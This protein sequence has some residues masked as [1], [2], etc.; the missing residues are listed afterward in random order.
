MATYYVGWDVGAWHKTVNPLKNLSMP[1]L[2]ML[3]PKAGYGSMI[4]QNKIRS[5]IR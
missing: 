5:G 1:K 4:R 2:I 3:M